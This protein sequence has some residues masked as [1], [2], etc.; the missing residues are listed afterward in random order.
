MQ[1]TA[2]FSTSFVFPFDKNKKFSESRENIR[3][4]MKELNLAYGTKKIIILGRQSL[5]ELIEK[6]AEELT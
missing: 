2:S 3:D 1:N 4:L 5:K 6:T